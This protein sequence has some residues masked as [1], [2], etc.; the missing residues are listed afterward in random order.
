VSGTELKPWMQFE[1]CRD[2]P[3][4]YQSSRLL[5]CIDCLLE[6]VRD[7]AEE[8]APE[9]EG[10]RQVFICPICGSENWGSG[11]DHSDPE[12]YKGYCHGDGYACKFTWLRKNDEDVMYYRKTVPMKDFRKSRREF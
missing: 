6:K 8:W 3:T 9:D 11:G 5:G 2:C 1:E 10:Y 4:R 12:D 7:A